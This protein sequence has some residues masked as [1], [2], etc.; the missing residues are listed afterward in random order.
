MQ[1]T[2]KC[3]YCKSDISKDAKLCPVCKKK[4]SGKLKFVI[5][6][7][8][9]IAI[10]SALT[11]ED[12]DSTDKTNT[13]ST[14]ED[15]MEDVKVTDTVE[16]TATIEETAEEITETKEA[17][18]QEAVAEAFE[19]TL[20][21]GH[22]TSGIDF[23]SG[24]YTIVATDGSGNVSS[25]NMFSGGLNELMAKKAD[26]MYISEFK[27]AKLEEDTVLSIGGN[28]TVKL[29][30]KA[31]DT[32][33]MTS[34]NNEATEEVELSSGNYVAGT[35][36]TSGVYDIILVKGSGNVSSS[37]MY[38]GGLNEIMGTGDDMYIKE[39]KNASFS[40]GDTLELSGLTVKLVP[41]K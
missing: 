33:G 13:P 25:S 36:F 10:I 40:D 38:N 6:A 24:T 28:L 8:I 35:D 17:E 21:S 11:N 16:E 34:R 32:A 19:T 31:A 12:K 15:T 30:T 29:T 9:A 20:S 39:F 14:A 23:P 22:Y 41:S 7:I 4:Q 5:I 3:K 27:N 18:Q 2:K 26:D 37:N 1:D